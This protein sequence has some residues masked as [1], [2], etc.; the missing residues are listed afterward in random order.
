MQLLPLWND[1]DR[2]SAPGAFCYMIEINKLKQASEIKGKL[3]QFITAKEIEQLA[4]NHSIPHYELINPLTGKKSFWFIQDEVH[5][6]LKDYFVKYDFRF[7][8]ELVFVNFNEVSYQIF[9]T[10]EVPP[11]LGSIKSLYKL[12][13]K[14]LNTPPGI[15]FL[16]K[17]NEIVYVGKAVNIGHRIIEH[18]RTK[19]FTNVYFICCHLDQMLRIEAACIKFFKPTLNVTHANSDPTDADKDIL[20]KILMCSNNEQNN[21]GYIKANENELDVQIVRVPSTPLSR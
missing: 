10:D 11:A 14:N 12:P 6:W 1:V 3:T 17:G 21:N 4:I 15:Y 19:E 5:E 7:T 16:C 8:P 9:P 18:K 2:A 13:E 20:E